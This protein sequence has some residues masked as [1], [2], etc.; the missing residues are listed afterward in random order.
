MN[1]IIYAGDTTNKTQLAI[2]LVIAAIVIIA[3]LIVYLRRRNKEK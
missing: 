1:E 2:I 3:G